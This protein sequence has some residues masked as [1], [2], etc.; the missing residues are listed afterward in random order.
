MLGTKFTVDGSFFVHKAYQT[1]SNR[2]VYPREPL[3][4]TNIPAEG[5]TASSTC[6]SFDTLY[7]TVPARCIQALWTCTSAHA[8]RSSLRNLDYKAKNLGS[9]HRWRRTNKLVICSCLSGDMIGVYCRCFS[10]DNVCVF[11]FT[12]RV[13]RKKTLDLQRKHQLTARYSEE[14]GGDLNNESRSSAK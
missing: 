11:F 4:S 1:A 7:T 6:R 12:P 13:H 2:N 8:P 3:S 14:T 5:N 9:R 10:W